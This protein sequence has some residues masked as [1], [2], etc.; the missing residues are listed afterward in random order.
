MNVKAGILQD[1][2]CIRVALSVEA[3]NDLCHFSAKEAA[4]EPE[5]RDANPVEPLAAHPRRAVHRVCPA[6]N[7]LHLLSALD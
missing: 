6:G 5:E 3:S 1:K 4:H 7:R 2:D